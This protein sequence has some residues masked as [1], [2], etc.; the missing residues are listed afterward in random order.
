MPQLIDALVELKRRDMVR[1]KLTGQDIIVGKESVP[2]VRVY[3]TGET[4]SA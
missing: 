3:P 2:E 1:F 4:G